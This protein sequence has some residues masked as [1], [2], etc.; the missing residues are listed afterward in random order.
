MNGVKFSDIPLLSDL[1]SASY[2]QALKIANGDYS[3]LRLYAMGADAWMLIN[4]FAELR[5]IPGYS[6]NGL[7]G[8]LSAGEGCNIERA[9]TWMQYD[10]GNI[11]TIH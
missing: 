9:M 4:K 1:N 8:V 10:N 5:Q 11:K 6:I 7:T 2:Q 3:L